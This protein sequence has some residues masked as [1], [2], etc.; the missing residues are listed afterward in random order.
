MSDTKLQIRWRSIPEWSTSKFA[1]WTG[2]RG[3]FRA[4]M[5][6]EIKFIGF[7]AETDLTARLRAYCAPS[8]TWQKHKAGCLIHKHR[9]ELALEIAPL[10]C[11][12]QD[13]RLISGELIDRY[14]PAWNM[15]DASEQHRKSTRRHRR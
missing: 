14:K 3:L 11:S 4:R 7:A 10:D 5:N 6:G 2:L 13:M 8:G 1:G 15:L 12:A 9:A